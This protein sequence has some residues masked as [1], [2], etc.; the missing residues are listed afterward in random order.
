MAEQ[1]G[2]PGERAQVSTETPMVPTGVTIV[3]INL[4][5]KVDFNNHLS[6]V[7]IITPRHAHILDL[8]SLKLSL[9][10][11]FFLF[12][13]FFVCF[14]FFV[15]LF[16]CCLRQGV[17]L[18]WTSLCG[19]GQPH[20]CQSSCLSPASWEHRHAAP[21]P[22]NTLFQCLQAAHASSPGPCQPEVNFKFSRSLQCDCLC[23]GFRA[24]CT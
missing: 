15:S 13:C 18:A 14:W 22:A 5:S 7:L 9:N 1:S 24:F 16:C 17:A 3:Q 6:P 10:L 2:N 23:R 12:A 11:N 21:R 20:T 4:T 8:I 19:P